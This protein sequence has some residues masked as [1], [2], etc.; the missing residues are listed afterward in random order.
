MKL[1]L[2][3]Q[4]QFKGRKVFKGNLR[5]GK[6]RERQRWREK[7]RGREERERERRERG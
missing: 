6:K 3:H 2:P 4:P 5:K 7:S 1:I